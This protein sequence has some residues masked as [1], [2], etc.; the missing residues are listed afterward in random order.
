M[1]PHPLLRHGQVLAPGSQ[2][3]YEPCADDYMVST[4]VLW[5]EVGWIV[6]VCM[7][8]IAWGLSVMGYNKR[9]G[10]IVQSWLMVVFPLQVTYLN[11]EDVKK[12]VH[13]DT[14]IEWMECAT[15]VW[16]RCSG[17]IECSVIFAIDMLCLC[18]AMY[19]HKY[20]WSSEEC[21]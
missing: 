16:A 1:C 3:D 9:G 4:A 19:T 8:I 18:A 15:Q 13:A 10:G 14:S 6:V 20:I 21:S 11:R 12:A 2:E 7:R 17:L 5:R